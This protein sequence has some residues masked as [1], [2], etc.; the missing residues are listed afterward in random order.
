MFI[1]LLSSTY[2]SLT[3]QYEYMHL[4][5]RKNKQYCNQHIGW[6]RLPISLFG[7]KPLWPSRRASKE[8]LLIRLNYAMYSKSSFTL[9]EWRFNLSFPWVS[10]LFLNRWR[11]SL[12]PYYVVTHPPAIQK[13][14]WRLSEAQIEPPLFVCMWRQGGQI[15]AKGHFWIDIF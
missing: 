10:V 13:Q 8:G 2:S 6:I 1:K 9:K 12:V 5:K 15:F 11:I 14:H 3:S 7:T 4:N